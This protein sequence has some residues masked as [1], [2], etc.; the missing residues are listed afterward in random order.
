MSSSP[1]DQTSSDQHPLPLQ[2]ADSKTHTTPAPEVQRA[3]SDFDKEDQTVKE[4]EWVSG[5]ALWILMLPLCCTFFLILLDV[6]IIATVSN[7]LSSLKRL[8]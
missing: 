2:A 3:M 6:S 7:A 1:P 8:R 4:T 5:L